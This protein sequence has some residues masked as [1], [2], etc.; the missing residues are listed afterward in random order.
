MTGD[1][2]YVP[3]VSVELVVN[4]IEDSKKPVVAAI[5]GLAL[6]GG[7]ELAMGCHARIAAPR[8]QLGLPELT[9][10]IIP[11]FGGKYAFPCTYTGHCKLRIG[12]F[13]TFSTSYRILNKI[14]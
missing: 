13:S 11:G 1:I 14:Y 3:D 8:A 9:L 6:G 5:E 2:S 10:G 12:N 7:L 4:T